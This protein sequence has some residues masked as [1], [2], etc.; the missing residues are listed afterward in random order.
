LIAEEIV[1][2]LMFLHGITGAIVPIRFRT[3]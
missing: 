1:P 3:G 2:L